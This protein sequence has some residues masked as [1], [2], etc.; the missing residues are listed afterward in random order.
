MAENTDLQQILSTK[1]YILSWGL[2]DNIRSN[3]T[4]TERTRTGENRA[5]RTEPGRATGRL[6][7]EGQKRGKRKRACLDQNQ[8]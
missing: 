8:N 7:Y 2:S 3:T 1:L 5:D 6:I 4:G